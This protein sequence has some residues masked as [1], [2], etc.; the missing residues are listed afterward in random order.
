MSKGAVAAMEIAEES[1]QQEWSAR[2]FVAQLFMGNCDMSMIYPFP[3]QTEEDK[4]TGDEFIARLSNYLSENLDPDE[5]DETGEIPPEV[6]KG[7]AKM[8]VFAMKISKEYGGL[9]LS[10]VNYNRVMAMISSYCASTAVTVSAHQSIG[11]PQPLKMF[12]TEKQKKKYLPRFKKGEIAAFALTEPN[13]GSDP[14]RMVT[15]AEPTEDGKHYIINGT[16][17]WC[18]NS[19]IADLIVVM[20]KTP[21]KIV[22]GKERQQITAFLVE[23]KMEGVEVTQRCRFMGLN[24]MQNGLVTFTNV[25]V[26]AENVI[27]EL[28]RG[29]KM[30]LATL[31]IGRL[32]IPAAAAGAARQ[33]LSMARRFASK[34]EQWGQ[35]IGKHEL[36]GQKLA[37]IASTTFAMEAVTWISSHFADM[38]DSDLR[39]EAAMSK[40]FCSEAG[41]K[42]ADM[43]LQVNGGRGYEKAKSLKERG[44]EPFPVERIMRDCR[45]NTIIEGTSEIMRLFIARE[46]MDPHFKKAGNMLRH[47]VPISVKV[48]TLFQ[49]LGFYTLWYPAQWIGSV[50]IKPAKDMGPMTGHVNY[51]KRTSHRL[52]RTVFGC[53][54]RYQAKLE[55]KQM[56]LGHMVEIGMELFAMAAV[57]SYALSKAKERKGDLT[58]YELADL[59]C[60][61]ARR[62]IKDHFRAI[63]SN[64]DKQLDKVADHVIDGSLKWMEEEIVWIGSKG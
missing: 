35:P 56:L 33:C 37:H 43:T 23:R 42:I 59:F 20:A 17:L 3:Q 13:V 52:A 60:R 16:K 15:T 55:R 19:P 18:T 14:A 34:R 50:F 49:L 9:G 39:M 2:S 64:D 22:R 61:Q 24:G 54:A 8:G 51:V 30:A 27:G 46:A 25:K 38:P 21:P 58:P 12:G 57:S 1:R 26:P 40:F 62:R 11:V 41:W 32:T 10:Q 31:N 48:K 63:K 4:K 6:M 47:S 5:V 44:D 7:M 29:L 28:G 36:T 53:M 45:I